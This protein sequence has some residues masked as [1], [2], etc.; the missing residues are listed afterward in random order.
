MA[1]EQDPLR[2]GGPVNRGAGVA[3]DPTKATTT[4]TTGAV[5]GAGE[6]VVP[7]I[8]TGS[9]DALPE[10]V[11][12]A[13]IGYNPDGTAR[14]QADANPN[15]TAVQ[16]TTGY[17]I[18]PKSGEIILRQ[19]EGGSAR[20]GV[21]IDP[22]L[23]AEQARNMGITSG[24]NVSYAQPGSAGGT[25]GFFG[26]FPN[27]G[28]PITTGNVSSGNVSTGN[29]SNTGSVVVN[30]PN[31]AARQSAYDLLLSE[32][33]AIGLGFLVTPLKG[34]I[35]SNLPPSEFKSELR[36]TKAYQDR[37][38]A[39]AERAAKGLQQL[40]EAQYLATEDIYQEIMRR[41]GLPES[42]YS[43]T[44]IGAQPNFNKLIAADVSSAELEDRL[45][46]A[47]DRVLKAAP[48]VKMSLKQFYPNITDGDVLAYVLNPKDAIGDIKRKVTAA[49][50]G[51]GAMQ[52]GLQTGVSRAEELASY[53]VTGEAA[54]QGYQ[55]IASILPRSMQ[56]SEIYKQ[57]PYTQ[58]TAEQEVFGISGAAEAEKRRRQLAQ[59]ETA[60]FSGTSGAAGGALARE[61]AGQF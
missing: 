5:G 4:M 10:N 40:N 39:N 11:R 24:M 12:G 9:F 52:S 48:E 41:Y 16:R 8:I 25:S 15:D 57:T 32:M 22:T 14:K 38:A 30:D 31:R 53:G 23:S 60:Q 46:T 45:Q 1:E 54:R 2:M 6:T 61:R 44:D 20:G 26:G 35:E 55:A 43:K 3:Y 21:A 19:G 34:L 28:T 17:A 33:S 51:A 59:L 7:W 42:Y 50:I 18:D 47:Y 29:V 37:F 36:K 56:L 58:A 49:E 13:L 27:S